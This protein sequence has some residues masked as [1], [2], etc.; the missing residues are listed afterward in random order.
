MIFNMNKNRYT[1][2]FLVGV[3]DGVATKFFWTFTTTRN[4][5]VK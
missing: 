5:L 3:N 4:A 1:Y 2:N